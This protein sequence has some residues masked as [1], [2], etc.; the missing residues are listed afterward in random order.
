MRCMHESQ[1]WDKKCFITLTYDDEHLPEGNTLVKSHFQNFIKR[2][3]KK[4]GGNLKYF[5]CGEYGTTTGRP[6]YHAL[7]YGVDFPDRKQH[8]KNDSG[9]TLWTSETLSQ[10]WGKG[11]CLI[12]NLT[13]KTAA[14]TARYILKKVTGEDAAKHYTYTD[15]NT[16]QIHRRLPEYIT[17]SNRPGIGSTWFKK[18]H[19]DAFPSDYLILEGKKH[20]VPKYYTRLLER[21]SPDLHAKIKLQRIRLGKKL[22]SNATPERL[23]V[24]KEVKLSQ[25]SQLKRK[26]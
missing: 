15:I 6:H 19:K 16:G 3:R 26:L 21:R 20:P 23:A 22:R 9:D 5:H 18:Y 10:L 8:S 17:S 11:H 25:L 7:L 4:H 24:R 12:G 13:Y 2:L 1:L 14:Y